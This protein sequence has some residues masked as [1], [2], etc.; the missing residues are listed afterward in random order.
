[1]WTDYGV[2]MCTKYIDPE[3]GQFLHIRQ[4]TTRYE[5]EAP[6]HHVVERGSSYQ[7]SKQV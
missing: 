5:Y 2:C 3:D 1:M 4:L 7:G 6:D